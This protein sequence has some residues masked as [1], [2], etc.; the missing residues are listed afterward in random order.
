ML[1]KT[2]LSYVQSKGIHIMLP[3]AEIL[4]VHELAFSGPQNPL[5][6]R[7]LTLETTESCNFVDSVSARFLVPGCLAICVSYVQCKE[8]SAG[9]QICRTGE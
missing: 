5:H 1:M 4:L 8:G 6:K 7:A 3:P 9:N 2:H